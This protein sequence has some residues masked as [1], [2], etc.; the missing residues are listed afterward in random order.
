MPNLDKKIE[1]NILINILHLRYLK[2]HLNFQSEKIFVPD[3]NGFLYFIFLICLSH[4]IPSTLCSIAIKS[5]WG[6]NNI[7]ALNKY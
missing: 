6:S 5:H 7:F 3:E 2:W 1:K 4:L